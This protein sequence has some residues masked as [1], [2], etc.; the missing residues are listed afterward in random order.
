MSPRKAAA[1]T[2]PRSRGPA[3]AE[4][5]VV[6]RAQPPRVARR[7]AEAKVAAP[8]RFN[9]VRVVLCKGAS[10]GQGLRL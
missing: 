7:R 9:V 4:A 2:G 8:A 6:G 5:V 1:V 3:S 10:F